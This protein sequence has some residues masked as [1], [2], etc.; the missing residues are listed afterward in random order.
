MKEGSKCDDL[1]ATQKS[2]LHSILAAVQQEKDAKIR[3]RAL[4]ALAKLGPK[5]AHPQVVQVGLQASRP[6]DDLPVVRLL[7]SSVYN[8]CWSSWS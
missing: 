6:S 1:Q 7:M 3:Q 5:A 2:P 4:V 8:R